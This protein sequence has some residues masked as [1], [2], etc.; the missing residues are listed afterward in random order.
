[1]RYDLSHVLQENV[2]MK[3]YTFNIPLNPFWQHFSSEFL[4]RIRWPKS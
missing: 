4:I 1:M 2:N 3:V